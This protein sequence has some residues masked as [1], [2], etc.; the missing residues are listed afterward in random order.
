M[1]KEGTLFDILL[2]GE[3]ITCR[4]EKMPGVKKP[5]KLLQNHSTHFKSSTCA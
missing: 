5:R 4:I 2:I 1:I 3:G